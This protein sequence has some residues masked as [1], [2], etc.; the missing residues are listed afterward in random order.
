MNSPAP[1]IFDV[2]DINDFQERV[3]RRSLEVP[4]LVDFWAP[5][6]QPCKTLT[7]TLEKVVGDLKGAVELAKV[8]VDQQKQLA[9]A[10]R[11]QS[12]PTVFL[13]VDGQPADAFQGALP[14]KAIKEWLQNYVK[15]PVK[16]PLEV[17]REAM[18]AGMLDVA[19]RAFGEVLNGNPRHGEALLGLAR[20]SL[21]QGDTTT[22]AAYIARIPEEDPAFAQG[23]RLKGVFAFSEA[24]GDVH[25]LQAR[26][27]E[28]PGDVEAWYCLGATRATRGDWEGACAAFLEVVKRDR[29]VR[30]DGGRR[31][32]LAIFDLLGGEDPV[33][34]QYRRKLAAYLF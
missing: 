12:I 11:I 27:A 7:P 10:F 33:V 30:E 31:A 2:K 13:F 9:G 8:N 6:C 14:E 5:W 26:V 25:A 17:A 18:A 15:A 28:N 16:D 32:L 23:Q 20:V 1:M 24:A 3:M 4:V 21:G 29:Q 22:A 34:M 19:E